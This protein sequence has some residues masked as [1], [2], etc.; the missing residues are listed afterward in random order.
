M[1]CAAYRFHATPQ[2]RNVLI[3]LR[4]IVA[5]LRHCVKLAY[6]FNNEFAGYIVL[7]THHLDGVNAFR[8]MSLT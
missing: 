5:V 2:R 1:C 8:A 3:L 4:L 6:L 7:S